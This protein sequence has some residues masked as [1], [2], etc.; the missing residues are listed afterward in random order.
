MATKKKVL[1][2]KYD[3]L[4]SILESME[5]VQECVAGVAKSVAMTN[6]YQLYDESKSLLNPS[7]IADGL[8]SILNVCAN[9]LRMDL[10]RL[11]RQVAA[12]ADSKKLYAASRPLPR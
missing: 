5:R 3:N 7:N 4:D 2:K 8:A 10:E 1:P 9:E 12:A 11:R 6:D